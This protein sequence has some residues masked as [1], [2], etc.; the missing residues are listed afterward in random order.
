PPIGATVV[1][2][3][4]TGR[5]VGLELLAQ[6]LLISYEGQRQVMTDAKDVLT[7]VSTKSPKPAQPTRADSS[8]AGESADRSSKERKRRENKPGH[9]A[10]PQYK[11]NTESESNDVPDGSIG[12]DPKSAEGLE[13]D[14]S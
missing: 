3:Q 5:V 14:T 8:N 4:G 1:T 10:P 12:D 9:D 6:K 7:V 13:P 11:G 2:K